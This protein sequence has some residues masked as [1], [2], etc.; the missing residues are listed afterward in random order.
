MNAL[1]HLVLSTTLNSIDI[2]ISIFVQT[3]TNVMSRTEDVH[4][5]ATT[6]VDR[7]DV[8]AKKATGFRL[9]KRPAMVIKTVHFI[10]Q[11]NVL[12]KI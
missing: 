9:I 3:S 12:I 10:T 2:I 6:V 11:K 5:T 8:T 1:Q 7:S 4:K